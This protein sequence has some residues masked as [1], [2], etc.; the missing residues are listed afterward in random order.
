[1]LRPDVWDVV[2][3]E[4]A[5]LVDD[6]TGLPAASWATPSL[7]AGWD[8][9][10]VVTHLA[11]TAIL[12]LPRFAV[13]FVL[14]G[15]SPGRIIDRQI[16]AGRTRTP[17]ESLNA[18]RSAICDLPHGITS[19]TDHHPDHRDHRPR[20]RHPTSAAHQSRLLHH[21]HHRSSALSR[22][23]STLRSEGPAHGARTARHR[24]Q[25]RCRA[26]R[27]DRRTRGVTSS[28]SSRT[29]R[30]PTRPERT[31]PS[32]THRASRARQGVRRLGSLT[33]EILRFVGM[34][35]LRAMSPS[36]SARPSAG[37]AAAL[38]ARADGHRLQRG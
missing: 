11:A 18:L 7:C 10:D 24:R 31:R 21:P 33:S 20:R 3:A 8:V 28:S 34:P 9:G 22:P 4:R 1:M 30:S 13:E 17:A 15:L 35:W 36:E 23:R 29:P 27:T 2:H 25:H 5:N 16:R 32:T 38:L 6:L 12:S 37:L 14:T 26:R 19:A